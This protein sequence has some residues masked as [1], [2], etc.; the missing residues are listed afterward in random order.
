MPTFHSPGEVYPVLRAA[1]S[2][3]TL[4]GPSDPRVFSTVPHCVSTLQRLEMLAAFKSSLSVDGS[5]HEREQLLSSSFNA[6]HEHVFRQ[7]LSYT[8]RQQRTDVERY[9]AAD[10]A[11][12]RNRADDVCRNNGSFRS[13]A[14]S[15]AKQE[16]LQLCEFELRLILRKLYTPSTLPWPQ[17]TDWR[18]DHVV[19]RV[20]LHAGNIQVVLNQ[21]APDVGVTPNYLGTLFKQH[22][23][24]SFRRYLLATRMRAAAETLITAPRSVKQVAAALGY[25]DTSNFTYDF[26][27]FF[28]MTPTLYRAQMRPT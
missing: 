23:G 22:A 13:L 15:S 21:L 27:V 9:L 7:W 19:E 16:H 4:S 8:F 12:A 18:V 14:P 28:R 11:A 2:E 25:T 1:E 20:D 3:S 6:I 10:A 26:R 24:I 5:E 17:P